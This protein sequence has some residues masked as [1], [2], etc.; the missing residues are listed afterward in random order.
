MADTPGQKE[1]FEA[2]RHTKGPQAYTKALADGADIN[3]GYDYNP[4]KG[5]YVSTRSIVAMQYPYSSP[6]ACIVY[7][8]LTTL[9]PLMADATTAQS[10]LLSCLCVPMYV[11]WTFFPSDRR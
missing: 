3:L 10:M 4:A 9:A 6:M 2:V 8:Y 11:S 7:I 1:L 5:L